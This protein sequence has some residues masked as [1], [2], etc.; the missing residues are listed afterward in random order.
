MKDREETENPPVKSVYKTRV[1]E[2]FGGETSRRWTTDESRFRP[3]S[4][5]CGPWSNAFDTLRNDVYSAGILLGF[6]S[7]IIYF[8]RFWLRIISLRAIQMGIA[9][10]QPV[11]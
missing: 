2:D 7:K 6:C 4:V 8:Y 1:F 11:V 5:V 3:S 10:S 9:K